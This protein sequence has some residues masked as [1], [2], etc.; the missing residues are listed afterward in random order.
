LHCFRMTLILF[1]RTSSTQTLRTIPLKM[2][3]NPSPLRRD[4]AKHSPLKSNCSHN[5]ST[6][7]MIIYSTK[8]RAKKS[9][10]KKRKSSIVLKFK[11]N[12][13]IESYFNLSLISFIVPHTLISK[14][15]P[16]TSVYGALFLST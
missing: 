14:N 8:S 1:I 5:K 7:D 4:S 13:A 2:A 10:S 15:L 6:C 16:F 9:S 11:S 12:Q 3:K